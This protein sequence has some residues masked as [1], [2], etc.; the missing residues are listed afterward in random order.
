[1]SPAPDPF[2]LPDGVAMLFSVRKDD[3]LLI[4][5]LMEDGT[6]KK[7]SIPTIEIEEVLDSYSVNPWLLDDNA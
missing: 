3:E 2:N 6:I 1:V 4:L 7:M 5:A